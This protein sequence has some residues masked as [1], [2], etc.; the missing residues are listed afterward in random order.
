[1]P[2]FEN[3]LSQGHVGKQLLKFA[4]PF[5]ISNLIQSLYSVADMIIV[6]QFSGTVSMSGVNIG[7]QVTMLV[8][9]MVFGLSAAATVLVAQ[10]KGAG[11]REHMQEDHRYPVC[12]IDGAWRGAD[13]C[14]GLSAR[15]DPAPDSD[16][17]TFF[18]GG[19]QLSAGDGA[20]HAVYL[21]L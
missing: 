20:W 12:R 18:C 4:L 6:G 3:D 11:Q 9:N 16:A 7:S 15:T 17:G 13:G 5:I 14:D 8:T 10:Y 1:M 21:R 2:Q 19:V